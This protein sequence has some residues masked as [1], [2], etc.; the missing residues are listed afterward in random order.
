MVQVQVQPGSIAGGWVPP[1]GTELEE[2]VGLICA[3]LCGDVFTPTLMLESSSALL[4]S[5]CASPCTHC[6]SHF[7]SSGTELSQWRD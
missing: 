4:A 6:D 2:S 1:W 5:L 7:I 3:A